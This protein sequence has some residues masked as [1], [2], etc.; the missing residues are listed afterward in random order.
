MRSM[1]HF[2]TV[3]IFMI[4]Q[5]NSVAYAQ[6]AQS[7]IY[8]LSEPK[9]G[10]TKVPVQL[11][12]PNNVGAPYP[13]IITQ[14]GS[15]RDGLKFVGGKGQTDEYS[16]RLITKANNR[17]YAV[18]SLDA[19]YKKGLNGQKRDLP[20]AM[21]Y[22]RTIR[23]SL[24]NRPQ[25]DE[26]NVFYTGFSYGGRQVLNELYKNSNIHLWRALAASEPDCNTFPAPR[27]VSVPLLILKGGE[28]HY[29]PE[30]CKIMSS[31][32]KKVGSKFELEILPKSNHH[33]SHNGRPSNGR[34]FNGCS[35]N[36]VVIYGRHNMKTVS[37]KKVD[38]K[39]LGEECF[40]NKA[41]AGKGRE[42]LDE[43]I[44]TVLDFFDRY[45]K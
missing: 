12:L 28:S 42:D 2:I 23:D 5:F 24:S 16:T 1:L 10:K 30:P 19:F 11:N 35:K 43:A 22:A 41:G 6:S 29:P 26:E 3:S 9:Y 7:S 13:V 18:I 36:P 15:E 14:H 8:D 21:L 27:K 34:A 32:Y 40:T 25:L 37:G 39:Y 38:I 31:L 45:R 4:A 20:W 44:E 17:G 33:F